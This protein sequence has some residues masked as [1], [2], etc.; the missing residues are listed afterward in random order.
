M[1]TLILVISLVGGH[2]GSTPALTSQQ[3]TG[4]TIKESC[5]TEA[6]RLVKIHSSDKYTSA[7]WSCSKTGN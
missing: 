5:E 7:T 4:F 3:I 2:G 6:K 1:F